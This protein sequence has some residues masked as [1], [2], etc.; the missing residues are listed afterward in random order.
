MIRAP[1]FGTLTPETPSPNNSTK[2]PFGLQKRNLNAKTRKPLI[3]RTTAAHIHDNNF[4]LMKILDRY[5][6]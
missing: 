1:S 5:T 4:T 2:S 6:P 3:E